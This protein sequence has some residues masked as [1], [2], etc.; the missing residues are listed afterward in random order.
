ML[1]AE[2]GK[3]NKQRHLPQGTST[4]AQETDTKAESCN[5][6]A[7]VTTELAMRDYNN[8]E[9]SCGPASN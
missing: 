5:D 7:K 8:L 4:T 6:K 9:Q 1:R 2:D 3:Q